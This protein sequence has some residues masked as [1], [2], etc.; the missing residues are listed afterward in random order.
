MCAVREDV[1]ISRDDCMNHGYDNVIRMIGTKTCPQ[2]MIDDYIE[3]LYSVN[4]I[5]EKS[6]DFLRMIS[7][8]A[9]RFGYYE[10]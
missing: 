10:F 6:K 3:M 1:P 9:D 2:S 4:L 7:K 8:Y 5:D